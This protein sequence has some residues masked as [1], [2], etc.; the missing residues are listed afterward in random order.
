MDDSFKILCNDVVL[1]LDI[2]LA[3]VQQFV[4]QQ[5]LEL[6]MYYCQ[7]LVWHGEEFA[8]SGRGV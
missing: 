8:D 4:W 2:S 7:K 1:P 6:V 5:S 3:A